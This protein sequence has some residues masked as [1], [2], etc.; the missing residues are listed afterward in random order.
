MLNQAVV[1]GR[2]QKIFDDSI[3]E[4]RVTL[5]D[6][7]SYVLVPVLLS[8]NLYDNLKRYCIEED[9]IG[10]KGRLIDKSG[11]LMVEASKVSFLSRHGEEG[12][13]IDD[14]SK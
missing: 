9:I 4:L 5:N 3:V 12:G 2:I 11:H 8:L 14:S 10:V 13:N 1:V 7:D 6:K